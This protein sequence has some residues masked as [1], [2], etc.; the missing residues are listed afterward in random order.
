[1]L[2]VPFIAALQDRYYYC[3]FAN[4]KIGSEKLSNLLKVIQLV[5]GCGREKAICACSVMSDSLWPP[6]SIACQG[7]LSMGFSPQEYWSRLPFSPL[8]DLPNPG[9]ET[10]SPALAGR[11]FT[12]EPPGNHTIFSN[13]AS[14]MLVFTSLSCN[15][16][17]VVWLFFSWCIW[18]E[19]T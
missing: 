10:T 18:M 14:R 5:S 4:E 8:G 16:V 7:P 9:I 11:F 3:Y 15:S 6:W 13:W 17:Q 19:V 12:A 1:M 2:Y